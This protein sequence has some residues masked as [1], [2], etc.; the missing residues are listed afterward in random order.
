MSTF[1]A[2]HQRHAHRALYVAHPALPHINVEYL[3]RDVRDCHRP[4]HAQRI[5]QYVK[6]LEYLLTQ[7][8]GRR[9][10]KARAVD[11]TWAVLAG[12]SVEDVLSHVN[13]LSRAIFDNFYS[14]LTLTSTDLSSLRLATSGVV[15]N[16]LEPQYLDPRDEV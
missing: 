3:I 12:A 9:P 5:S 8:T 13:W 1:I 10:L 11:A 14:L 2:H 7:P 15:S 16:A 6:Y 4:I